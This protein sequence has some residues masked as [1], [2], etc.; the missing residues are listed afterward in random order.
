MAT[1]DGVAS[2]IK[3]LRDNGRDFGDVIDILK[4]EEVELILLDVV[5][6][7]AGPLTGKDRFVMNDSGNFVLTD[8]SRT[9]THQDSW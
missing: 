9:V 3:T 1:A 7:H 8:G 6:R 4:A 2:L 5:E